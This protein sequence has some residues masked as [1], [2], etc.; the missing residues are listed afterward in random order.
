MRWLNVP[1]GYEPAT[2][3]VLVADLQNSVSKYGARAL[4][5]VLLEAGAIAQ[6]ISL[7]AAAADLGSLWLG[8]GCDRE[9]AALVQRPDGIVVGVV[10]ITA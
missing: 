4:R 3:I 8:G 2:V 5:F 1:E 9:L 7:S 6:S 10:G